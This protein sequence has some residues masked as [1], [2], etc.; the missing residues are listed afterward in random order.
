LCREEQFFGK[1]CAADAKN[2]IDANIRAGKRLIFMGQSRAE[3]E[4]DLLLL[5]RRDG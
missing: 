1:S 5:R 4:E 2:K 3:G